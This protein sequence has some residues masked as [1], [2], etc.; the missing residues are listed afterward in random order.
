MLI[1][2]LIGMRAHEA[3]KD[4]QTPG[5]RILL[6]GGYVQQVDQGIYVLLPL[7]QRACRKVAQIIREEMNAI[8]GQEILMPVVVPAELWQRSGRY[9]SVGDELLRFNDRTGRPHVLSMTHEEVVVE[10]AARQVQSYK[11]FPFM[12]YQIQTK[13]RD[14][15][16][17]RGGLIRVREFTMKDAYSFHR[18]QDDLN[19]CYELCR[20][21]YK[22][23]FRRCGLRQ[24]V[25]IESDTGMMGG[26]IAHEYMLLSPVGE[27]T[28]VL[29]D[30]CRYSAN[31][32][33]AHTKRTFAEGATMEPLRDAETPHHESIE[34]VA[35]FLKVA[36]AQ[37]LKAVAFMADESRPVIAFVRGDLEVCQTKLRNQLR[38]HQLRPMRP[39]ELAAGGI[40]PGY[41]GPVGLKNVEM[42]FDESAVRTPNLVVGANRP[43]YHTMGFNFSRDLAEAGRLPV[44]EIS[45]VNDGD[46]CP[47]CGA[48]LHAERG[49]EVGNTFQL[50]TKYT[51][52]MGVTYTEEDGTQREPIMGCY[53]IGVGRTMQSVVEESHDEHGPLWPISI[54]PFEV[55][56]LAL[57]AATDEVLR[58]GEGLYRD[59]SAAGID[60]LLDLRNV[61]AGVKLADADLI[62]APVRVIVSKRNLANQI[63]EV[64]Y[65]TCDDASALPSQVPLAGAVEAIRAI[66]EKLRSRYARS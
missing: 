31:R 46:P 56:V 42:L 1:D 60:P 7:A 12:L 62:G 63:A 51:K 19:R 35:A 33:V 6:R 10:V 14:E 64:K 27:D 13:F 65:R 32:E 57:G 66:I 8:G 52:A 18:T 47:K 54:A 41:I 3:P 30:A 9:E 4:A 58:A 2:Q 34:D 29:C 20:T 17:S 16:R 55:E 37:C 44:A 61:T 26:S 48:A 45:E 59:L 24:V 50:G 23:I 40:V 28:L 53:G 43:N 25:E 36:P 39:E 38:V 11:Q 22:N 5:H 49:I 15:P 21:A